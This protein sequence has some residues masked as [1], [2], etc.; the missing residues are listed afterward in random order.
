MTICEKDGCD[1][2][3]K[4]KALCESHY[5]QAYRISE[6]EFDVNDFWLFIKKELN[7]E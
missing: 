4:R 2:L 7:L 3:T 1:K 5:F 6:K